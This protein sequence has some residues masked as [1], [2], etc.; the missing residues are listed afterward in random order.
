MSN[1]ITAHGLDRE[2]WI[3]KFKALFA[4]RKQQN[5]DSKVTCDGE[6]EFW[7]SDIDWEFITPEEAVEESFY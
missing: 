7:T 1:S 4:V 2:S 3:V 5:P 6:L